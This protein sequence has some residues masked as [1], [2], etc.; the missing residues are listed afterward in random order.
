MSQK[1]YGLPASNPGPI[2]VLGHSGLFD[3]SY[4]VQRNPDL[5]SL[6]PGVLGHYH[7]HGWR[8]GR[9]PNAYFDPSWY[10]SVNRDVTTDPLLHYVEIGER[11]GRRPIAWFDP[12]WYAQ[13]HV[14]PEGMLALT[15]FLRNRHRQHVRPIPEFD[16]S[17]YLKEYPDVAASGLDP[18]EH[19][20]IQGF[21][22]VRRP[23]AGFDPLFYRT[24]YLRHDPDA[25]PLLHFLQ[26]RGRP[27]M[28]PA[29]PE[30]ETTIPREVAR[31]SRP[32]PFFEER[33]PLPPSAMRRARVLA[34]Y[35]PQFHS[36]PENDAWWGTG[37]T[38]WVNVARGLPRF[39]DHYQPRTPRDLGH[40]T[41]N[42]P[43]LLRRQ[44]E[45]ARDAGIE[46]FIFYFYW[47]NGRRLLDSPLE[48]LLAHPEI[49]LPFCLMWANE[50]WSR[51]WDGSEEDVLI[52]QDYR[53]ED[54]IALVETLVRHFDDPR[55][56]RVDGRPLL[57]IYRADAIPDAPRAI[58]RWRALFKAGHRIDP[59]FIMGQA[60]GCDDPRPMG[61]DGAIEFPPHKI[62]NA[63][64][65]IN[66]T[67]DILDDDF[68]A[69]VYDYADIVNASLSASSPP[70]P[71]IRTAAP[72][73]D[74]DARRQGKGLVMHGSTPALYERWLAGLIEQ[75]RARPFFGEPIV[76]INA[77][78]EWA[79]GAY[80]EPDQ[81]FGS[82]YLNATGR[83]SAGFARGLARGRMLLIGHDAFE[84]GAQRL[85]LHIGRTLKARH[86]VDIAFL[87]LDAGAM[88]ERYRA[89]APTEIVDANDPALTYRLDAL[90]AEGFATALVNSAASSPVAGALTAAGIDY[91]LLIHELPG[92]LQRRGLMDTLRIACE[93]ARAIVVPA[94]AIA[95][96]LDGFDVLAPEQVPLVIPQ[97][98]YQDVRFSPEARARIR[99]EFRLDAQDRLVL[100][101]G[102]GDMRKGFDLF[103]QA[104]R[105]AFSVR[106]KG[107]A[108]THF[109][110]LGAIDGALYE[111]LA[112]D[113]EYAVSTGT[114]HLT[115]LV[116][117]VASYLSAADAFALTSRE[118]PYPS[119][120]L[121]ALASGLSCVAFD[122]SGGIPDL[123]RAET[124]TF[125]MP[126]AVVPMGDL[127][128]MNRALTTAVRAARLIPNEM[129][130]RISDAARARFAFGHYTEQLLA[131]AQPELPRVSI[132]VLSYNYAR[133]MAARLASLFAQGL[134]VLEIVVLD[135]ASADDSVAVAEQTAEDWG[136]TIEI[137]RCARN[138]GSVFA[139]WRH[140][141]E[142]ARGDWIWIAEADDL[143]E[144]DQLPTL[145][146]ALSN[147]PDAVMAFCDSRTIDGD[148][149]RLGESYKPYYAIAADTLLDHDGVHDG[150][151]FVAQALSERNLILN[152]S[153]ALFDRAALLAALD[154]CAADLAHFRIAGDWRIYIELLDQPGARVAYVS[155]ACNIHRR[156]HVSATHSLNA[157]DHC[158]DVAAIHALLDRRLT[159]DIQRRLRQESYRTEIARQLGVTPPPVRRS[160]KRA[161][162]DGS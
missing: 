82:A 50:S 72:S 61:M 109:V 147:A 63:C 119:V 113:I 140:A 11:Q 130:A 154:R 12:V 83:A 152:A 146:A 13:A 125:D 54:E 43:G 139:Q 115:G 127:A 78:N 102:Y 105:R 29:L 99:S 101:A 129:R 158:A 159:P 3:A 53:L 9:K 79:E 75:A 37:F 20:M 123:L 32:G 114:L 93:R 111:G 136:R 60:F 92:L 88:L 19:Y 86:G 76:C 107:V 126:H 142:I 47:F 132:V 157:R 59:I 28:H 80:L 106:Q 1:P 160:R 27:G 84:A 161:R 85:L 87:L 57:M 133:F 34:Y 135:D 91:T 38:E 10:L 94:R 46:G 124:A 21:R 89:V 128:R 51:R 39:A 16:P 8:E 62:A 98:L 58:A 15:H 81:H 40:Y 45:M 96:R 131:I 134:P 23:F 103:L 35:L 44:A 90:R 55:Y 36:I 48:M 30:E 120:V 22:E 66:S 68:S 155:R 33:R 31:R 122:H 104:W 144:P 95:D 141:A 52:T 25:N 162:A 143:S 121:E 73:W 116:D 64:P 156:H 77:W 18:L 112:P 69:Q 150:P 153:S 6:G 26:H 17:F 5:A 65:T 151:T 149:A 145:C 108:R 49:D 71:L 137:V 148:G 138:S 7:H 67:L 56:I 70:F 24:R 117:D 14:V 100:G 110:W 4:Y 2:Q 97:G 41:L 42:E 118:D 74:N